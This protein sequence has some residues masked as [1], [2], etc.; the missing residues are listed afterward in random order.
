MGQCRS[1]LAVRPRKAHA[2]L[3]YS[4]RPDGS[5]DPMSKH[6]GCPVVSGT[7]WAANLWVWN[8][9]RL[10]Y[11]RAP[12]KEGASGFDQRKGIGRDRMKGQEGKTVTSNTD[13]ALTAIFR[14]TNVPKAKLYFKDQFMSDLPPGTDLRFNSYK[15]I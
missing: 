3:F 1:G 10:G 8:R 5:L 6:G 12:R 15:V 14:N 13:G 2:V 11:P 4:Q 7:K 9:V